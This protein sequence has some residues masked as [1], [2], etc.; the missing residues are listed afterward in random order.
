MHLPSFL[1]KL[2]IWSDRMEEA[3]DWPWG[4]LGSSANTPLREAQL[5]HLGDEE[6]PSLHTQHVL[7]SGIPDVGRRRGGF[8]VGFLGGIAGTMW[9]RGHAWR[10]ASLS[11]GPDT[12]GPNLWVCYQ[13]WARQVGEVREASEPTCSWDKRSN[14]RICLN[15]T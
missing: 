15:C 1:P 2:W 3:Q 12:V 4:A 9:G 8:Q 13:L 7:W 11:A 5:P 10:W 14:T 6:A